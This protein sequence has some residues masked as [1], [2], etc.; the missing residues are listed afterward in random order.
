M[1][2]TILL[3]T[4]MLTSCGTGDGLIGRKAADPSCYERRGNLT[5]FYDYRSTKCSY[6]TGE[7]GTS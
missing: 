5:V 7:I 6:R 3:L 4:L 1:R 2:W